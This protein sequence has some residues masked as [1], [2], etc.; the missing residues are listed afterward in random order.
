MTARARAAAATPRRM[1]AICNNLGLLRQHFF[2]DRR[3]ARA[4]SRR[5]YLEL[6]QPHRNDFTVFSGVSHP[7]VDG[8]HPADVCFLTCAPHPG[9]GSFR[10]TI[11]LDQHIAERIGTLDALPVAHARRQHAHPQPLLD[12][13]RAWPFRPRTRRP[14]CSGSC[15]SRAR[16]SRSRRRS[17]SWTPARASSTPS[18]GTPGS[19]SARSAPR[20]RERL[21]Q[22]FTS[23]RD[24]EGRLQAARGWERKPKPVVKAPRAGRSRKPRRLPGEGEGD[25]RPGAPGVPDRLDPRHH[26]DARQRGHPGGRGPGRAPRSPRATTT[27]R[28]TGD[29]R[30]SCASSRPSMSST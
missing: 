28:T 29:P 4:T 25:V 26:P 22:Y 16:P 17:G 18:P 15:S 2:P 7:N 8:G 12:R 3:R 30:R 27:S 6:L 19:W 20:D 5:R 23:V 1:F 11:S 13:H 14:T 21:D 9:S 24:L 10:N